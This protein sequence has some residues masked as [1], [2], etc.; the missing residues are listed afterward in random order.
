MPIG[1]PSPVRGMSRETI[2]KFTRKRNDLNKRRKMQMEV[3]LARFVALV[4]EV[5]GYGPGKRELLAQ[6]L[7]VTT[8]TIN[9]YINILTKTRRCECC[10]QVMPPE[11]DLSLVVGEGEAEEKPKPKRKSRRTRPPVKI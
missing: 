5:G 9:N 4:D 3:R 7:G 2:E 10:G 6:R 1:V 8:R 11:I